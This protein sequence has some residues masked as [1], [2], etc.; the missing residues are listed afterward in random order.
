MLIL[1]P[2]QYYL[3]AVV[4]EYEAGKQANG[5]AAATCVGPVC[6]QLT[7]VVCAASSAIALVGMLVLGY[8]WKL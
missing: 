7:Y 8:R 2:L 1:L 3:F 4:A 5:G 6:F